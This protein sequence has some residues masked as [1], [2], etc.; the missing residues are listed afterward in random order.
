MSVKKDMILSRLFRIFIAF[1]ALFLICDSRQSL[2]DQTPLAAKLQALSQNAPARMHVAVFDLSHNQA[3]FHYHAD[4]PARPA[5][6][7]KLLTTAAAIKKLGIDFRFETFLY[8]DAPVTGTH[9]KKLYLVGGGDPTFTSESLWVIIRKL[10]GL[11]IRSVDSLFLDDGLFLERPERSG[12]RAF[13][14]SPSAL[15]FNFN[16]IA[17]DVCPRV[18]G[19]AAAVRVEPLELTSRVKTSVKTVSSGHPVLDAVELPNFRYLVKGA[20]RTGSECDPI[21]R[22]V[23]RPLEYLAETAKQML[24]DNGIKI[25]EVKGGRLPPRTIKLFKHQ[26]RRLNEILGDMNYYSNNIIAQQLIFAMGSDT[27]KN[28]WSFAR[29]LIESEHFLKQLGVSTNKLRVKDGSGLSHDNRISANAL[30]AIL[31]LA[32]T[33]PEL[34]PSLKGALPLGGRSGTLEKRPLNFPGILIRAK[35]G[36]LNGVTGLA[37]YITGKPKQPEIAFVILGNEV[38]SVPAMHRAEENI[39]RAVIDYVF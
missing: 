26:S 31:R 8:A 10:K 6:T 38:T 3:L 11:G 1:T 23:P 12:V 15:L 32:H 4:E 33:D 34:L 18:A 22:S 9:V 24:R 20:I 37:G 17:F 19:Q 16:S 27:S 14:A 36:T 25:S 7:L 21:F 13:E 29:G 30:L 5:S 28:S 2:A 35:T 39:V